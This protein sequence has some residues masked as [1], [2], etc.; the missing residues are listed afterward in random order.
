MPS[1]LRIGRSSCGCALVWQQVEQV[2]L[3]TP[4]ALVNGES[5]IVGVGAGEAWT[6]HDNEIATGVADA[7][8]FAPPAATMIVSADDG[9]WAWT[10][11]DWF[12]VFATEGADL[13][14][15]IDDADDPHAAAGY[16]TE[17]Y[18]DAAVAEAVAAPGEATVADGDKG[19][20]IVTD[21]GET[22]EIDAGAVGNAE[23][24]NSAALS[25]IGRSA[26]STG[27]VADIAASADGDVLRRS[28]TTVGFGTIATAGIADA[29]VTPA[30]LADTAVTPGSYTNANVTVDAQGRVTAAANGT[31]I[32]DGDKGDIIVTD[33]GE[34][35]EIDAGA[36]GNAELADLGVTT[37]KIAAGAVTLA[38]M[39][40][41]VTNSLLGRD[42]AGAGAVEVLA[43]G[44][45]LGMVSGVVVTDAL[46]G[47]VTTSIGG[48]VTSLSNNVVG[49]SKF[50]DSVA[51]SVIG[52]SANSTGDPGDIV[53][54]ADGDVLRRSGATVGFGTIATAGIA[55]AA[56]TPAKLNN[57]GALSAL[58]RSANSAGVRADVSATAGEYG[59]LRERGSALS[60][61]RESYQ[62]LTASGTGTVTVTFTVATSPN[63]TIANS[64]AEAHSLV[65]NFVSPVNGESGFVI[66][67][68]AASGEPFDDTPTFNLNGSAT[69]VS[70]FG[71]IMQD[72]NND[73]TVYR[74][75]FDGTRLIVWVVANTAPPA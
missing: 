50:R 56:V 26:N 48:T 37:G 63:A 28:G 53:A 12:R 43:L 62:A 9:L 25:V 16:A 74:W 40:D 31:P 32:A 20:I 61:R 39:A 38:K 35:W 19:D 17:E 36:V 51:L 10:G 4:P 3:T 64:V 47:A 27:A 49:D 23:L 54:S 42:T 44:G 1:V 75:L 45:G 5:W 21:D 8:S 66:V 58:G 69:N 73:I 29:A 24:R 72:G 46:S 22:W 55:D 41:V 34:T 68:N 18:V 15:H 57:G 14:D 2:G 67:T 70:H 7:W 65:I 71:G 6:T 52:R 11:A 30:K 59:A 13:T 60:F 33:D